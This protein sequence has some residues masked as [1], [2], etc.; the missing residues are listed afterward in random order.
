[1]ACT[2]AKASALLPV[3]VDFMHTHEPLAV[4][5]YASSGRKSMRN[6]DVTGFHGDY[7]LNIFSKAMNIPLR[8]LILRIRL[9]R[10]RNFL[11][12]SDV[13]IATVAD[14]S[15]FGSTSQFYAHFAA[16]YGMVPNQLRIKYVGA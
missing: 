15:G 6:E 7:A 2:S 3:S 8:Q 14:H 12:E 13:A 4:S 5:V 11:V 10:A 16:A 9:L 1:M